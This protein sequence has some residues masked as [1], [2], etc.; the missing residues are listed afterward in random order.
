[1]ARTPDNPEQRLRR[2]FE[3][4]KRYSNEL[5][6]EANK[7]SE[8]AESLIK[9][10]LEQEEAVE[11]NTML[12]FHAAPIAM[13]QALFIAT[14]ALTLNPDDERDKPLAAAFAAASLDP[15]KPHH[16]KLLI[17]EFAFAHF[18]PRRGIGAPIKWFGDRYCRLLAQ[19]H[20]LKLKN[21]NLTDRGA[22]AILCKL[23]EYQQKSGRRLSVERLRKA[24]REARNPDFN[25]ILARMLQQVLT[26]ARLQ[27]QQ[28]NRPWTSEIE[29]KLS[30]R[31]LPRLIDSIAT[32]WKTDN[33][34]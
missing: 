32:N 25:D 12:K 2:L 28:G 11:W 19:V 31:I 10:D 22:C 27:H 18:V 8:L 16:W 4:N 6:A 26:N 9:E 24:L 23:P 7:L 5:E 34:K 21:P 17:R 29:A 15:K 30:R 14:S 13:M 1:M 3:E 33:K 20:Q